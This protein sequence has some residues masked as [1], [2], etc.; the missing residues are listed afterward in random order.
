MTQ[1]IIRVCNEISP[2][3]LVEKHQQGYAVYRTSH[4]GNHYP[5]NLFLAALGLPICLYD[6]T[7]LWTDTNYHPSSRIIDG[8]RTRIVPPI[9]GTRDDPLVPF[10]KF[11]KSS[12]LK[13]LWH[14]PAHYHFR[15]LAALF[16]GL[17][18][19]EAALFLRHEEKLLRVLTVMQEHNPVEMTY[20][21]MRA[22][23]RYVLECG[24]MS[25]LIRGPDDIWWASCV[26]NRKEISHGALAEETM[27]FL[28]TLRGLVLEPD[29]TERRG[30]A[31][32]SLPL[33]QAMFM[34][35]GWWESGKPEIYELSGPDLIK[36]G[37]SRNFFLPLRSVFETL[38]RYG[39]K[40]LDLPPRLTLHIVPTVDLRFGYVEGDMAS[41][42]VIGLYE[43]M[44]EVQKQK[45][46]ALCQ[47]GED[48]DT[49]F[50]IAKQFDPAISA[51]R[52]DLQACL[53]QWNIFYDIHKGSFFSH[54][55]LQLGQ[56]LVIPD[57]FLDMPFGAMRKVIER[58]SALVKS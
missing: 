24:C 9:A 15:T 37:P 10:A 58:M 34:M 11:P 32:P 16:P 1:P 2:R 14:T 29:Q 30:G 12:P 8:V 44:L 51:M 13:P 6:K 35:V 49:R 7:K 50:A 21:S 28:H 25:S 36:Y 3:G 48:T 31:I 40:D 27:D 57:L 4:L 42:Q 41:E 23:N 43:N 18:T 52:A 53:P 17:V 20:Q 56:R 45:R 38:E 54:H 47:A 46:E 19:T 5:S 39:Q 22:I 26:H 33:A 55:D